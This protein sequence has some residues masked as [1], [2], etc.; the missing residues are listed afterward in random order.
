MPTLIGK[1]VRFSG[2]C[3]FWP[4]DY[5]GKLLEGTLE[6]VMLVTKLSMFPGAPS[7][8]VHRVVHGLDNH[9]TMIQVAVT[10]T[11]LKAAKLLCS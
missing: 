2:D 8:T 3:K 1:L 7:H 6:V 11:E 4:Y 5:S 10:L 9:G